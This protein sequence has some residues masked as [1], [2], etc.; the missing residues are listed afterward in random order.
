MAAAKLTI[1]D[2]DILNET[3]FYRFLTKARAGAGTIKSPLSK[4]LGLIEANDRLVVIDKDVPGPR[5]PFVKLQSLRPALQLSVSVG[6]GPV[7]MA[8]CDPSLIELP[9]PFVTV[10]EILVTE[11]FEASGMLPILRVGIRR[12]IRWAS[13]AASLQG[14]M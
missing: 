12:V 11:W 5:I 4:V 9:P 13:V 6:A 2:D 14:R 8:D 10:V 3:F 7:A 1:V